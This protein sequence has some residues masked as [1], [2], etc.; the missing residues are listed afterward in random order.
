MRKIL[1]AALILVACGTDTAAHLLSDAGEALTDASHLLQD[2]GSASAQPDTQPEAAD[3]ATPPAGPTTYPCDQVRTVTSS[4][5][6]TAQ[7]F[8]RL[9]LSER[10]AQVWLCG[11]QHN[12]NACPPDT[13]CTGLELPELECRAATDLRQAGG[14]LWVACDGFTSVDAYR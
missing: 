6:A 12:D 11:A 14:F 7:T 8:A 2:A 1:P 9:P 4:L 13:T 5:N 10:G 3:A